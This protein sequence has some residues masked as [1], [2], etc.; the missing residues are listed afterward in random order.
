MLTSFTVHHHKIKGFSS[1]INSRFRYIIHSPVCAIILW[2]VMINASHW[3]CSISVGI[4]G[5]DCDQSTM[6]NTFSQIFSLTFS[7]SMICHVTFETWD[8][9]MTLTF[10]SNFFSKFLQLIWKS[11]V[12]SIN[13]ILNQNNFDKV[14]RGNIFEWCSHFHSKTLSHFQSFQLFTNACASKFMQ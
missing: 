12:S 6:K 5:T 9:D 10:L 14:C 3:I 7:T 8:R 1:F 13:S 11:S 2:P 4:C